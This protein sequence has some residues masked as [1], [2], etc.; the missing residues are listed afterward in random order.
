MI[1]VHIEDS[2]SLKATFSARRESHNGRELRQ[3]VRTPFQLQEPCHAVE[4]A[5]Q[6]YALR[7]QPVDHKVFRF[8]FRVCCPA[9]AVPAFRPEHKTHCA[10]TVQQLESNLDAVVKAPAVR[11][12]TCMSKFIIFVWIL[13]GILSPASVQRD[14]P[15]P[16][17][18]NSPHPPDESCLLQ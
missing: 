13:I 8:G 16:C 12:S 4:P 6:R 10:V 11:V 17:P 9:A 7:Q 2:R 15:V 14:T 5:R 1:V 3:R 18:C